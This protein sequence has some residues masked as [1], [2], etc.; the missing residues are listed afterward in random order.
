MIDVLGESFIEKNCDIELKIIIHHV[1]RLIAEIEQKNST[2]LAKYKIKEDTLEETNQCNEK[3]IKDL[4]SEV[5]SLRSTNIRL[6]TKLRSF[7]AASDKKEKEYQDESLAYQ[8]KIEQLEK[9][10]ITSQT[11]NEE[12]LSKLDTVEDLKQ[13]LDIARQKSTENQIAVSNFKLLKNY[14]NHQITK[15]LILKL[16]VLFRTTDKYIKINLI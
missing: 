5:D 13:Q 7:Q 15:K 12:L 4:E 8:R 9:K 2:L 6:E 14:N 11:Q 3:M 10:L 1:D 16:T